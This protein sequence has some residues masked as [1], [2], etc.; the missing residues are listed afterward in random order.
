M[1]RGADDGAGDGTA[2]HGVLGRSGD[3]EVHDLDP[4]CGVHHH[5]RGLHIA[6]DDPARMGVFQGGGRLAHDAQDLPRLQALD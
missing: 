5:V 1:G 4:T 2:G 6:V 3:A